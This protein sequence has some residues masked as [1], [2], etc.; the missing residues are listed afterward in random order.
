MDAYIMG[1]HH[2][3]LETDQFVAF[4]MWPNTLS[5]CLQQV[6]YSFFLGMWSSTPVVLWELLSVN[7]QSVVIY[8]S[9]QLVLCIVSSSIPNFLFPHVENDR[10]LQCLVSVHCYDSYYSMIQAYSSPQWV[11]TPLSYKTLILASVAQSDTVPTCSL[12][13]R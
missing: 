1:R 2:F 4:Q 5:S 13:V 10:C 8:A 6:I 7:A 11:G 9:K 3:N 12:S